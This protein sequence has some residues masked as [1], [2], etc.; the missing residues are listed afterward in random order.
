[1]N[2]KHWANSWTKTCPFDT[3][4]HSPIQSHKSKLEAGRQL[5]LRLVNQK[6]NDLNSHAH[7][8]DLL[9]YESETL[10]QFMNLGLSFCYRATEPIQ[11]HKAKPEALCQL[12]LR[13]VNH[14]TSDLNSHARLNW[15][16][17]LWIWSAK[18]IPEHRYV[19]L[20]QGDIT[21]PITQNQTWSTELASIEGSW[22]RRFNELNSYPYPTNLLDYESE[23]LSQFMN[24]GLPYAQN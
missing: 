23:S 11:S 17:R 24:L 2:V 3:G 13:L 4:R 16:S 20:I 12:T 14:K 21:H 22:I 7:L 19:L 6:I 8:T 1:M 18:T 15:S 9:D 5:V 10:S